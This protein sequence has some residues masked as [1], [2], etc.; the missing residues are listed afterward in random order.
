LVL[1]L[2]AASAQ[3]NCTQF[4]IDY[5]NTCGMMSTVTWTIAAPI[6]NVYTGLQDCINECMEYPIDNNCLDGNSTTTPACMT[7][8]NSYGCRRYHLNVAMTSYSFAMNHCPH[9]T[10]L[11]SPTLDIT[12]ANALTGTTCVSAMEFNTTNMVY[13]INGLLADFCN[14]AVG[15]CASYMQGLTPSRCVALYNALPGVTDISMYPGAG[16]RMFPLNATSGTF[17][18]PCRRYHVSVARQSPTLGMT[19]CPHALFGQGVCGTDCEGYCVA[20][21]SICTGANSQYNGSNAATDCAN[22][23]AGFALSTNYTQFTGNTVQCRMYHVSVASDSA[24]N[25][26]YH[27]PH[28]GPTGGGVCVHSAAAGTTAS[29]VV[30]AALAVLAKYFM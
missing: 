14:S 9:P 23:C 30:V 16:G 22:A 4:C 19:H 6:F 1:F 3:M 5:N 21:M 15:G 27:C 7:P 8:M 17:T 11:S 24:A 18:L 10:P 13:P 29:F 2:G 20:V 12:A 25:A 28:A 26:A